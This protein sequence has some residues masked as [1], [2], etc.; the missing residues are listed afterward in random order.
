VRVGL[1]VTEKAAFG[2]RVD[3]A[4]GSDVFGTPGTPQP[5]QS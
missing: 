1:K 4:T 3:G 5:V 2:L